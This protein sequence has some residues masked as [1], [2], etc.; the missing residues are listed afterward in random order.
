MVAV[1]HFISSHS[2]KVDL[3][4]PGFSWFISAEELRSEARKENRPEEEEWRQRPSTAW[5]EPYGRVKPWREPLRQRQVHQDRETQ[6]RLVQRVHVDPEPSSKAASS[7]A[8]QISLQVSFCST[9]QDKDL[10][11]DTCEC[12]H[13]KEW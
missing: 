12:F 4:P 2:L 7:T 11:Q 5:F 9:L 13:V 10:E 3:R 6:H 1:I 8:A